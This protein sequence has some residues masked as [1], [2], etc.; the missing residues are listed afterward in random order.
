VGALL[1][2]VVPDGEVTVVLSVTPEGVEAKVGPVHLDHGLER[3]EPGEDGEELTLSRVLW[4]L[5]DD[6]TVEGDRVRLTKRVA[7]GG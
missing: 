6:V 5:V 1:D 2:R 7:R 4:A 3:D